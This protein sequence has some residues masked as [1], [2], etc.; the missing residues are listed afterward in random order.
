MVGIG[1]CTGLSLKCTCVSSG[2]VQDGGIATSDVEGTGNQWDGSNAW[3]PL[4]AMLIEGLHIYGGAQGQQYA[5][6]LAQLWLSSSYKG[7]LKYGK[8]VRDPHI[9]TES[10]PCTL[11]RDTP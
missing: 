11:H 3:P 4:Q 2:L 9:L 8:M 7:W 10:V 1:T 5:D 6:T